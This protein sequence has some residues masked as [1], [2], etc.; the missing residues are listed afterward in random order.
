[1]LTQVT[2]IERAEDELSKGTSPFHKSGVATATFLRA[3]LGFEKDVMELA[4]NRLAEAEEVAAEYQRQAIRNPSTAH[5]SEIYP[6]GSEYDLCH[7]ESQLMSAVIGVLNESL[8]ESLRG[9][10]KLRKAFATLSE[11]SESENV[12]LRTYGSYRDASRDQTN[13]PGVTCFCAHKIENLILRFFL[14]QRHAN[15]SSHA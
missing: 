7:A 11:I 5:Y 15:I 1:M 3:A 10:Y 2:E 4:S 13:S 6:P 12:Y 14:N 8:T 9:F